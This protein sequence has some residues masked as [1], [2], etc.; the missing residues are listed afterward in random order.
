MGPSWGTLCRLFLWSDPRGIGGN[1][2]GLVGK[3]TSRPI[4]ALAKLAKAS[5]MRKPMWKQSSISRDWSGA[6]R[7][8]TIR[9]KVHPETGKATEISWYIS[10]KVEMV[11][12]VRVTV[13]VAKRIATK[14]IDHQIGSE[15][16]WKAAETRYQ[17]GLF[18]RR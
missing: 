1:G 8:L 16:K 13:E 9:I 14:V 12:P 18:L 7:G 2:I 6:Y 10:G 11:S 17:R 15:A 4:P 3:E 5:K